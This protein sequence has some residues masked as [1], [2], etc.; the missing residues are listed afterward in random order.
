M[1]NLTDTFAYPDDMV[2]AMWTS[3][4]EF[5]TCAVTP[6]DGTVDGPVRTTSVV[7]GP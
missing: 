4:G 1:W 7:V 5:W 6:N 2:D 3:A